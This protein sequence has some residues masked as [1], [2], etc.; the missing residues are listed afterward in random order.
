VNLMSQRVRR[1]PFLLFI[2]LQGMLVFLGAFSWRPGPKLGRWRDAIEAYATMTRTLGPYRFF[3]PP[4]EP[5]LFV[6]VHADGPPSFDEIL[7]SDMT[8][9]AALKIGAI[10]SSFSSNR[11]VPLLLE[12]ASRQFFE[13]HP[14]YKTVELTFGWYRVPSRSAWRSGERTSMRKSLEMSFQR[15]D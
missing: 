1:F 11:N 10:H 4:V 12:F 5:Q 8:Q 3:A 15:S 14:E 2:V 7:G 6:Q 13:R 9:E